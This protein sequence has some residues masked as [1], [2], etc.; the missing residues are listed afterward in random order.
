M[1]DSLKPRRRYEAGLEDSG[2][3][4]QSDSLFLDPERESVLTVVPDEE[5][6]RGRLLEEVQVRDDGVAV[7]TNPDSRIQMMVAAVVIGDSSEGSPATL[8]PLTLLENGKLE[9]SLPDVT[10]SKLGFFFGYNADNASEPRGMAGVMRFGEYPGKPTITS[11]GGNADKEI[12]LGLGGIKDDELDEAQWAD[13]IG[14]FRDLGFDPAHT[15]GQFDFHRQIGGSDQWATR[16][17]TVFAEGYDGIVEGL[18]TS[19]I[20]VLGYGTRTQN[21]FSSSLAQHRSTLGTPRAFGSFATRGGGNPRG[22]MMGLGLG[23]ETTTTASTR[24]T[25]VATLE[26]AMQITVTTE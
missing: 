24:P 12:L 21:E 8:V 25:A 5:R 17:L 26:A 15:R 11:E 23:A 7:T 4:T 18:D 19:T 2:S 13:Q 10:I 3:S 9:L 14:L 1:S 22:Q 6:I 16:P 20:Q